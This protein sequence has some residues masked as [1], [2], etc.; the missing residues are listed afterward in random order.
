MKRRGNSEGSIYR[1]KDG[2]WV[3]TAS[4]PWGRRKSFYGRSRADVATKLTAAL[5]THQDGLPVA[6]DR[7]TVA[8]YLEGWLATTEPSLRPRTYIRYEQLLRIHALPLVGKLPLAQLSAQHLQRLYA[9]RRS[10][11]SETTVTHLHAVI[12][13]ALAQAVKWDM[14]PRN[15]ASLVDK[16]KMSPREMKTLSP[17]EARALL[18][19]ARGDRYEALYTLALSTGARQGELLALRWAAVDLD[20]ATIQ[21]RASIARVRGRF[22]FTPPKTPRSRRQIHTTESVVA[23]LKR[24][25]QRQ[26][27]ERLLAGSAWCDND[28]VFSDTCGQPIHASNFIRC[29]FYPLLERA[30][31]PKVRFH[32][33]RHSAASLLLAQGVH[34]KIV[35]DLLGHS[36]IAITIDLYSHTT[37]GMHRE[38]A[39]ALESV[40]AR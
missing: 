26:L 40:L 3:G 9:D 27:A 25:R 36:T 14:L 21:I 18:D 8:S 6:S 10:V 37:E 11:I 34:P 30:G 15:V 29:D 16:P 32:D 17:E 5:K 13:K 39:L 33:L 24:H 22:V 2:R 28:L 38:A 1:R 12:H 7:Q 4:L 20:R 19:A 35:S 23:V 31:L